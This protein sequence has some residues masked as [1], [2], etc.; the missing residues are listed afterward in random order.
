MDH[1]LSWFGVSRSHVDV[2]PTTGHRPDWQRPASGKSLAKLRKYLRTPQVTLQR[3]PVRVHNSMISPNWESVK[4]PT[5][6]AHGGARERK[7]VSAFGKRAT[8]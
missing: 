4:D 3:D 2:T 5:S 7:I 6:A 1:L 8:V